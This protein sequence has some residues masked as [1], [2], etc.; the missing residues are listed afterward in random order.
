V[1]LRY[2]WVRGKIRE[3]KTGL[4]DDLLCLDG[5]S[6]RL[7]YKHGRVTAYDESSTLT[8]DDRCG[9]I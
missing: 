8:G 4:S 1:I 5:D 3:K 9:T 2:C 6:I 7:P